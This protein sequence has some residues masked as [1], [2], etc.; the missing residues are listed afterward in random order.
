MER[1]EYNGWTNYETWIVKL[2]LDNDQGSAEYWEEEAREAMQ[3]V[4]EKDTSSADD[5]R[6]SAAYDLA[7]RLKDWHENYVEEGMPSSAG[8]LN[9]LINSA[10]SE[11]NWEEIARHYVEEIDVYAAGWNM[12]GYMPDSE[13]AMFLNFDD[14]QA[15]L[16]ESFER[17]YEDDETISEEQLEE[18]LDGIDSWKDSSGEWGFNFGQYFYWIVRQ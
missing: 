3:D 11:V 5:L 13:P 12:P 1:K 6:N 7:G 8:F 18:I 15:S 9:D 16:K 2:W 17:H 14:A 10:L 4:V